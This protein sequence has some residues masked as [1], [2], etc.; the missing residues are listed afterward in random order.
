MSVHQ[1]TLGRAR[2]E[3]KNDGFTAPMSRSWRFAAFGI[4]IGL[5]PIFGTGTHASAA[6]NGQWSVFPTT[7]ANQSPRA[8]FRPVLTPGKPYSDAVTISNNT[9]VPLTFNLYAADAINTAGGGLSLRRRI[10]PQRDIGKWIELPYARI[11]VP[12]RSASVV[13]FRIVPP[14]EATPGDHVGGIVAEGIQGTQSRAGS[15]PITVLQAV[16]VRIYGRVVGPVHPQLG[17]NEMSVLVRRSVATEF[18]SSADVRVKFRVVNSGN[19]VL[20]PAA[21]VL[22][23]SPV[24]TAAARRF[25]V[26]EILPGS[27]LGYNL[28][29]PDIA[30]YGHL[31]VKVSISGQGASASKVTTVWTVP[32]AL[33]VLAGLAIVAAVWI[34]VRWR[35]KRRE[36]VRPPEQNA[37]EP[38]SALQL[39]AGDG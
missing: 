31:R 15:V 34:V 28:R 27:S 9:T 12:S 10:D 21:T 19:T 35:R 8:Y 4:L 23:T 24:G 39:D 2:E 16:G 22:L 13:P 25:V 33:L 7:S 30:T 1:T 17:L 37:V 29:F 26:N 36:R 14:L 11:T 6:S 32:W 5:L 38:K 3:E 18:S 20:S